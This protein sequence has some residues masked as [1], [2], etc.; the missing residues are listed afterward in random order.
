MTS[1]RS[2]GTQAG[3]PTKK[4]CFPRWHLL[5]LE[6]VGRVVPNTGD[7]DGIPPAAV[8]LPRR[9]GGRAHQPGLDVGLLRNHEDASST[10]T[11]VGCRG[12]DVLCHGGCAVAAPGRAGHCQTTNLKAAAVAPLR[13][14]QV[15][16]MSIMP[17]M[18]RSIMMSMGA[19]AVTSRQ[20]A[21]HPGACQGAQAQPA[22]PDPR[23][24]PCAM[25]LMLLPANL[26]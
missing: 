16:S 19:V 26:K 4:S 22:P 20:A 11:V 3:A 24:E 12:L 1:A 15:V 7:L 25:Q 23:E 10:S 18:T 5:S 9:G 21:R 6:L 17:V 8:S 13:S 14:D 2:V